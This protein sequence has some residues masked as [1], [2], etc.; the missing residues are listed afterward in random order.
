MTPGRSGAPTHSSRLGALAQSLKGTVSAEDA[1]SVLS[2]HD[3]GVCAHPAP[4]TIPGYTNATLATVSLDLPARSLTI[5]PG[6][7]CT[8]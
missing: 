2:D 6:L 1:R 5:T 3:A 8:A 7:P 4:S